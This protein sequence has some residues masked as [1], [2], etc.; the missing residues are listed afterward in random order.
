MVTLQA[1]EV[2]LVNEPRSD[3]E[4]MQAALRDELRLHFPADEGYE[5]SEATWID[6]RDGKAEEI[7]VT[8]VTGN[9]LY[10]TFFPRGFR[11]RRM[12]CT[13]GLTS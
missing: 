6:I 11:A 10:L 4:S 12:S 9:G 1:M 7:P 2:M 3:R 5:V 13:G 8:T